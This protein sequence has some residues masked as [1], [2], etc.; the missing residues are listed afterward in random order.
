MGRIKNR[1]ILLLVGLLVVLTPVVVL[2]ITFSF[3]TFAAGLQQGQISTIELIELYAIEFVVLTAFAYLVYRLTLYV[4]EE[5]L[6]EAL[7]A[8]NESDPGEGRG[9]DV[10]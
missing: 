5:H 1:T 9:D 10:E 3:L 4:V 8:V 6:P 2:S 7:D